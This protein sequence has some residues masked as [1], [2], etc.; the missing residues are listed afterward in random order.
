[1]VKKNP[2]RRLSVALRLTE[3]YQPAQSP[4][5]MMN[6]PSLNQFLTDAKASYLKDVKEDPT[7]AAA[8]TVVMGNEAGGVWSLSSLERL[9]ESFADLDTLASSI[10]YAWI[11]SEVDKVLSVPLLPMERADL[12]LRAENLHALKMA[13]LSEDALLTLTELAD[14]RPQKF[15]LVDHNRLG[16]TYDPNAEVV[17]IIDHHHDEGFYLNANPRTISPCGSSASLVAAL[18]PPEPPAELCTLLLTAVLLDTDGLKPGGKATDVD[19]SSALF[20]A[21][22]STISNSIPPLS[23]LSPID[24]PDPDA[25]YDAQAIKDLVSTLTLKKTDVSHLGGFDLLRRDYKEYTHP[26]PWVPSQPAIKVGLSTVPARLKAWGSDGRLE[27]DAVEWMR[28]RG[29]TILGVLTTFRDTKGKMLGKSGKHGKHKREMAWIILQ[30]TEMEQISAKGLTIDTL[31][32]RLFASLEADTEIEVK[33]HKKFDVEKSSH[34]PPKAKV[35]VYK[36]GNAQATRKA[37]APLVKKTLESTGPS[38]ST[39]ESGKEG[40]ASKY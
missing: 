40:P 39:A 36:Q 27:K 21:T 30:E 11:L 29:L 20:V 31:A 16:P 14:F 33:K 3:A 28:R 7:K 24:N 13:G 25:L 8:W 4:D 1:M 15:A 6:A 9:T 19:R 37:I 10:A 35:K 18:L 12:S 17:A 23:A 38:D 22:K 32:N 34:L 5:S 26:L 2:L